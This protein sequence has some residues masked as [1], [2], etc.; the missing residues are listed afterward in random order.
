[1]IPAADGGFFSREFQ[2]TMSKYETRSFAEP[3]TVGMYGG[4]SKRPQIVGYAAL[5]NTLSEPMIESKG[6]SFR[7]IIRPGAFARSLVE[8]R[9]VFAYLQHKPTAVLGSL[10][11]GTLRLT[12]DQRGLRYEIDPPDTQ[13]GRDTL[14][15][16]RRGDV[17]GASFG[18][19]VRRENWRKDKV[20]VLREL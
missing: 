4:T 11:N 2:L 12:E 1:A 20:G 19:L 14:E 10:E 3:A 18:F 9:A 7:E 17:R 5:F 13:D 16:V 6:R 8:R 15:L